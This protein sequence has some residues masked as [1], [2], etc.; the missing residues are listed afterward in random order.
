MQ[1]GL[2]HPTI[3]RA[4]AATFSRRHGVPR[5]D[6]CG[7]WSYERAPHGPRGQAR[8][9]TARPPVHDGGVS[10]R[11]VVTSGVVVLNTDR[12]AGADPAVLPSRTGPRAR[13]GRWRA[14]LGSG[15]ADRFGHREEGEE[16]FD[17][18]RGA[19]DVH[20]AGTLRLG[21]A[22]VAEKK[23]D[24]RVAVGA[25]SRVGF[26]GVVAADFDTTAVHLNDKPSVGEVQR[27]G[28][29]EVRRRCGIE[30]GWEGEHE[31]VD[32]HGCAASKLG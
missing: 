9:L 6:V 7:E 25:D 28:G 20:C 8:L 23:C 14:R 19:I 15:A 24:Q 21:K 10:L 26:Y 2:D 27:H 17:Q 22:K 16:S 4:T 13:L 3:E 5:A 1:R 30:Q 32:A 29:G 31:R 11:Y 18:G 12:L